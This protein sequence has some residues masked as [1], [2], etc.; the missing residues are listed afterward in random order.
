MINQENLQKEKKVFGFLLKEL[1]SQIRNGKSIMNLSLP[2]S[3]YEHQSYLERQAHGLMYAPQFLE[4][5]GAMLNSFEQFK[6]TIAHFVASLHLLVNPQKSFNPI[7]G[8]TFQGVIG[9]CP[10]YAEQIT[11]NPGTLRMQMY[12][13]RFLLEEMTEFEAVMS[14]N[15]VKS[16][17]KGY[18]KVE[19][20][21]TGTKVYVQYPAGV[22][23]GT[24]FGKR[25]FEFVDK[26]YV[27]DFEHRYYAEIDFEKKTEKGWFFRKNKVA[28]DAMLGGIWQ[29]KQGFLDLLEK[30]INDM[31]SMKVKF[32]ENEH[33]MAKIEGLEGCWLE[34]LKIGGE[35]YWRFGEIWPNK[36][37]YFDNPLPSDS[38]N[39]LDILYLRAGDEG[40]S[41][42]WKKEIE[43]REISEKKLREEKK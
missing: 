6:L 42:E 20:K 22:T 32:N 2:V 9:G 38:N 35:E 4:K 19:Y 36:L 29:V 7:L 18:T 41:Q 28:P 13:K 34:T 16:R 33:A 8:E 26:F 43:E 27:V 14:M 39:R 3:I 31:A 21:N 24:V 11:R 15:S 25:T 12:G 17:R 40:K 5:A 10:V 23:S 37:E 1:E 30:N